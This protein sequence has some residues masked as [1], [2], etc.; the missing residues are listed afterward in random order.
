MLV[1]ISYLYK[2]TKM[3]T[4]EF[5]LL[6]EELSKWVGSLNDSNL[7]HLLNSI[8]LSRGSSN[9]DWWDSLSEQEKNNIKLGLKDLEEGN[10]ISSEN[11]WKELDS[12]D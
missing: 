1:H 6:R 11:F 9:G 7:L 10:T 4:A 2:M 12:N 3:S 8:K 5:N